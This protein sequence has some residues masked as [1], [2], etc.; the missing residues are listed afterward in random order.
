MAELPITPQCGTGA[1]AAPPLDSGLR[2]NDEV[3]GGNDESGDLLSYQSL[4]PVATGTP[5]YEKLGALVDGRVQ[6]SSVPRTPPL[7]GDKPQRYISLATLG[8]RCSGDGGWCRRPVPE[9]IPDRSPGHAFVLMTLTRLVPLS[10]NSY[11]N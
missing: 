2:R 8:C 5:R 3:G 1:P 11:A 9:F 7:A 6:V 10:L 4:M